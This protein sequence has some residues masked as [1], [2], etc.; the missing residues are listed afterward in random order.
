MW[1][2]EARNYPKQNPLLRLLSLSDDAL[3]IE[4]RYHFA[5]RQAKIR[6]RL[7]QL[8]NS[9][10]EFIDLPSSSH[11]GPSC[12]LPGGNAA[13]WA[14]EYTGAIEPSFTVRA[15]PGRLDELYGVER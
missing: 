1:L 10:D 9:K 15:T 4:D 3:S 2:D 8:T 12:P 14:A 7:G 11:H 13:L 6:I 5:I